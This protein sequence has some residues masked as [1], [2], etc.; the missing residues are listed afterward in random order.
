VQ[1]CVIFVVTSGGA[2]V[3]LLKQ[4]QELSVE[5]QHGSYMCRPFRSSVPSI[6]RPDY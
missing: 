3:L 1:V 5:A 6:R 2:G 4:N